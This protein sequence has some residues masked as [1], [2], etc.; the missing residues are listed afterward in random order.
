M[1]IVYRQ[2]HVIILT[3][4]QC[5]TFKSLETKNEKQEESVSALRLR[6]SH[7]SNASIDGV[8][9]TRMKERLLATEEKR[10]YRRIPSD[11]GSVAEKRPDLSPECSTHP[12]N[13]APRSTAQCKVRA[14]TRIGL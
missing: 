1:L 6:D 12:L 10:R 11:L 4:I 5:L 13:L 14:D 2:H 3:C 8:A 7:V 9:E